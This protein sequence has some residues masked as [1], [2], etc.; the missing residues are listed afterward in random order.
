M[1][2]NNADI[3]CVIRST[4][5]IYDGGAILYDLIPDKY[6]RQYKDAHE[7]AKQLHTK[8]WNIII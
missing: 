1:V 8:T 2:L 6:S 4:T 7:Q 3:Q 5:K